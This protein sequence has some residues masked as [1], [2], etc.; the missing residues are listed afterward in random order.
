[1]IADLFW[2]N[3]GDGE[4]HGVLLGQPEL[5]SSVDLGRILKAGSPLTKR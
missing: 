1:M 4:K 2:F 5:R 3:D